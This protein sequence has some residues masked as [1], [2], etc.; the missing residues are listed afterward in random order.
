MRKCTKLLVL[1][2]GEGTR[3]KAFTF[4]NAIP[5]C[6]QTAGDKTILESVLAAYADIVN[7]TFIAC[8]KKHE[9]QIKDV[10][11]FKGVK[12][13]TTVAIDAQPNAFMSL[14]AALTEIARMYDDDDNITDYDWYVNWSD[15]FAT[16]PH[17]APKS[18][19]IYTDAAYRHRNLAYIDTADKL[20]VVSTGN[21]A[22]NVPGIF[23]CG[24]DLLVDIAKQTTT[25]TDFDKLMAAHDNVSIYKLND[26]TDLGDYDKFTTHM[27]D[28]VSEHQSR[29]FNDITVE[30]KTIKKRPVD[31]YGMKLHKIELSYYKNIGY[32]IPAFAEFIS[33]DRQSCTMELERIKGTTCQAKIDACS[34]AQQ[35]QNKAEK[36]LEAFDEAISQVHATKS[37]QV[38][39]DAELKQAMHA[40]FVEAM[41]KRVMPVKSLID[42]VVALGVNAI[43][44]MPITKD[45][46]K[47]LA[48]VETWF[49]NNYSSFSC[50][51]THG[52]P[53]TDNCM[54]QTDGKIRFIDPR[55]Y[56][57]GLNVLG[58]GVKQYDYAKFV[59]GM[60]GYSRFN[61]AA[62]IATDIVDGNVKTYIGLTESEGIQDVNMFDLD[63]DDNI[64]VL[65]GIIWVK[66]S[67]Y[68]INDPERSV[69][70]YL[71]GNALLT[72]LLDI[73]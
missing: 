19:I 69:L 64:K 56:F 26:V 54:V 67:S 24:G 61:R 3:N 15:V 50:G 51:I 25:E 23:F 30:A 8:L 36:L 65:V 43:D 14:K 16:M 18:S 71:Y 21:L 44:D 42:A 57:G 31:D 41:T 34:T 1:A 46:D 2:C 59:Y 62:F 68:I 45:Y 55:G 27:Q 73:K 35:K 63:I 60:T 70:A 48:A 10:L 72:K 52:D 9:Q 40:E 4:N 37:A 39:T 32:L 29:Y 33:Y 5:K 17:K 38:P 28:Y 20:N 11:A 47:L 12:N 13:F 58:Y 22:G 6:L 7:W 49:E 53:N 66:L